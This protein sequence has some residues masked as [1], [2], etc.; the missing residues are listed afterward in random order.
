MIAYIIDIQKSQ[1]SDTVYV[2]VDSANLTNL[3]QISNL[4]YVYISVR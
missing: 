2:F 1:I 4:N 3:R